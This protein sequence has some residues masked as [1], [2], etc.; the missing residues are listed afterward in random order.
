MLSRRYA[1][2][3]QE[4]ADEKLFLHGEGF[5]PAGV[6]LRWRGRI[7]PLREQWGPAA[8]ACGSS[9][10]RLASDPWARLTCPQIFMG[11]KLWALVYWSFKSK[12]RLTNPPMPK[13]VG[14]SKAI[15]RVDLALEQDVF[16][17]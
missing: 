5:Y 2:G 13:R 9:M 17:P 10:A 8:H 3:K 15:R 14:P 16:P 12:K 7:S 11:L 1:G 6:I 4:L